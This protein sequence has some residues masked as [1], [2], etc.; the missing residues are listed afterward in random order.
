MIA[1]SYLLL[2]V[3]AIKWKV[4]L[5]TE[6]LDGFTEMRQ[7]AEFVIGVICNIYVHMKI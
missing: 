3:E 2:V 1:V 6:N 5:E 4:L 7:F